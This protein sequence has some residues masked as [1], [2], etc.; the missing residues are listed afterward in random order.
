MFKPSLS[1]WL[2]A[3]TS[4]EYEQGSAYLCRINPDGNKK[5]CCLG[6]FYELF[7]KYLQCEKVKR[8]NHILYE[9]HGGGLGNVG[10]KYFYSIIGDTY[11]PNGKSLA[12]LNDNGKS[13]TDIAEIIKSNPSNYVR[14]EMWSE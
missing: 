4:G 6:V 14:L 1:K 3:L 13:F 7:H 10:V 11:N 9:E 8:D 5:F 2:N 12:S